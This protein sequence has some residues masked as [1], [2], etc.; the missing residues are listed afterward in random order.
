[1]TDENRVY[2]F[3]GWNFADHQV[4]NH[5]KKEYVRDEAY[6]NNVEGFFSYPKARIVRHLSARQRRA[7]AAVI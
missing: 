4:V 5:G 7:S 6:T 2:K 3:I 1:M